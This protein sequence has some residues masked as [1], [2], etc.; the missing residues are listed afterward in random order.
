MEQ[1]NKRLFISAAILLIVHIAGIIGLQ[2]SYRDLF[3]GL[4]PINLL[5]S[6]SLLFINHQQFNKNFILFAVITLL[7]GFFVEVAGVR[8]GAIFGS[9]W[10]EE[11]LGWKV[12][13]VPVVISVNWL[14]LVYS[15][16]VIS[17]KL[18]ANIILKSATGAALLLI[19]DLLIEQN[20]H[21]YKFWSWMDGKIPMQNYIAWFLVSF[22]LLLLF[23]SLKFKK[24]NKL[25]PVLYIVQ[26]LFFASALVL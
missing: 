21:N 5:L 3:L 7:S 12:L 6:A 26:L 10:Y 23:H 8:T 22:V 25:A 19:L 11:T 17:N 2:T 13:N 24:E 16:G 18:N 1:K 15:A 4:T 9:Y 14:M 20:A